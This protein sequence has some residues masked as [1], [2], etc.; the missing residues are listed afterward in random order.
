MWDWQRSVVLPLVLQGFA[1]SLGRPPGDGSWSCP[2][3]ARSATRAG[4]TC[5]PA[6]STTATGW[7]ATAW[8]TGF[9]AADDLLLD[10]ELVAACWAIERFY[11]GMRI[12]GTVHNE[13]RLDPPVPD[14]PARPRWRRRPARPA[15]TH[16]RGIPKHEAGGGRSLP[17]RRLGAGTWSTGR[18]AAPPRFGPG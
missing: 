3:G 10:E 9:A 18:G 11:P 14:P 7:S 15:P 13:L 16:Q 6:T 12:A 5:W 17:Y 8:S 4:S 2:T 1:R